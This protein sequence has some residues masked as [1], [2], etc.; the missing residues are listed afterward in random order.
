MINFDRSRSQ[1]GRFLPAAHSTAAEEHYTGAHPFGR[2]VKIRINRISKRFRPKTA[3]IL[4]L[5]KYIH[6]NP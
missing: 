4:F 2:P 3:A 6:D 5:I 1:P